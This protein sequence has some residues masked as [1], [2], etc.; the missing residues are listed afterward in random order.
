[1]SRVATVTPGQVDLACCRSR[2]GGAGAT[3]RSASPIT[4]LAATA[5]QSAA[6]TRRDPTGV[7]HGSA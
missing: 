3:L 7:G 1:V 6:G 5:P 2:G 4:L